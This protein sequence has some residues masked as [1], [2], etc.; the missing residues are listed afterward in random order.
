MYPDIEEFQG[1]VERRPDGQIES[2][3]ALMY[4]CGQSVPR[5]L[6]RT[7]KVIIRIGDNGLQLYNMLVLFFFLS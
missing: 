3:T 5:S 6:V 1:T 2:V 4:Y 7:G